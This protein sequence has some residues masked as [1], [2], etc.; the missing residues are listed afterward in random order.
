[1]NQVDNCVDIGFV[2]LVD[3]FAQGLVGIREQFVLD[4][5]QRFVFLNFLIIRLMGI[6]F[7][8]SR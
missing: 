4:R 5:C 1:M 8:I 3:G 6:P 7:Q 2:K